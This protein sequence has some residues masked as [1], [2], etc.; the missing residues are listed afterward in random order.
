MNVSSL[1]YDS[2]S[3]SGRKSSILF[4]FCKMPVFYPDYTTV[5][6]HAIGVVA[7][8]KVNERVKHASE[9]QEAQATY[10]LY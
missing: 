8:R 7:T 10:P 6:P 4:Q 1:A 2:K 9:K 5:Q 3:E